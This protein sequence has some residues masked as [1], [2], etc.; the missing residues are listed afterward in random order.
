MRFKL[1][2]AMT[3]PLTRPW[4][5]AWQPLT[6]GGVSGFA[7]TSFGRLFLVQGFVAIL[8]TVT[9]L[10]CLLTGWFPELE[11]ALTELPEQGQVRNGTL[12]WTNAAPVRLADGTFFA[13]LVDPAG[14][15]EQGQTADVQLEFTQTELRVHSLFGFVALPYP[16]DYV[17]ALNHREAW[18]WWGA[19]KPGI[20][21]GIAAAT[22]VGLFLSW[23]LLATL[24]FIPVR[25]WAL[26]TDREV[27]LGGCW[28]LCGAALMPG[29]LLM[30]AAIFLYSTR[31]ISLVG[32]LIAAGLHLV[33]PWA[34]LLFG[35]GKL[36]ARATAPVNPFTPPAKDEVSSTS[37][38]NPFAS[39]S[40][41]VPVNEPAPDKPT[42]PDKSSTG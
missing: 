34:Y 2:V 3:K 7:Y 16:P 39:A 29:A 40:V 8:A 37:S 36:A 35:A 5:N 1:L 31:R 26:I 22:I 33:V 25:I 27:T 23:T 12:E 19:W 6:F 28:R 11:S 10:W 9:V 41:A 18:P 30:T 21:S 4:R 13:V 20:V 42:E 24:Y 17:V 14:D 15:R 32:L 38:P